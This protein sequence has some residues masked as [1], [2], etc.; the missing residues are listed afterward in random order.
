MFDIAD[1]R[2]GRVNVSPNSW[3][4]LWV[5][6]GLSAAIAFGQTFGEITGR[7]SDSTGASVAGATVTLTNTNTNAVRTATSTDAGDY[8][9]PSVPP[10]VYNVKVERQG[11]KAAIANNAGP[12]PPNQAVKMTAQSIDDAMASAFNK[13]VMSSAATIDTATDTIANA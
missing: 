11:F 3:V 6:L 13:R 9:L 8:S 7:I 10:G 1:F 5:L 2:S 4:A 12:K